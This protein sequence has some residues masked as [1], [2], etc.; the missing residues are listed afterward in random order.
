[1][2]APLL[3]CFCLLVCA[4]LPGETLEQKVRALLPANGSHGEAMVLDNLEQRAKDAL[5]GIRHLQS[6]HQTGK[7]QSLLRKQLQ[8]SLGYHRLPWPPALQAKHRGCSKIPWL[9]DRE[10]CVPNPARRSGTSSPVC[11]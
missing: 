10:D 1:M 6:C 9:P 11:S 2:T 8:E 4:S 3:I 5:T 7:A